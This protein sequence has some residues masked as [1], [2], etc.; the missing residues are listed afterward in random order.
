MASSSSSSS[1]SSF[2]FSVSNML[3]S[4]TLFYKHFIPPSPHSSVHDTHSKL[5][6]ITT[7]L[8]S[9]LSSSSAAAPFSASASLSENK[10]RVSSAAIGLRN[11]CRAHFP[12]AAVSATKEVR[13]NVMFA[14]H[15][16]IPLEF[17]TVTLLFNHSAL[18]TTLT[19]KQLVEHS[20]LYQALAS[21]EKQNEK[22]TED[23]EGEGEDSKGNE[24]GNEVSH[25]GES[26]NSIN[27]SS[28]SD[29]SAVQSS[30]S[31]SSKFA[32]RDAFKALT[33][34]FL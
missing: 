27:N 15:V 34:Q 23:G 1:S 14:S 19:N 8:S 24:T 21:R 6:G 12:A 2:S 18:S 28:S 32:L 7:S 31:S 5:N 20:V 30:H 22:K 17:E 3:F 16:S 11:G 33:E 25:H 10:Q 26:E 29:D 13:V 9:S 4:R